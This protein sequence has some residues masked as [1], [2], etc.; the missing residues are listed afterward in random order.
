MGREKILN[1]DCHGADEQFHAIVD[2]M[3]VPLVQGMLKYAFKSDPANALGS[4]TSGSCDKEWAEGW[5]FAAAVLPRLNYCSSTVADFVKAN[6]DT[7]NAAPMTDGFRELKAKVELT[8]PCLGISCADV[9]AFQNSAGIYTG[10][11]SATTS[12]RSPVIHRRRTWSRIRWW[13]WT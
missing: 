7:A 1:Y 2:Q 8:Y 3:T 10:A 11:K 5:A 4:C 6:L 9:G 13:T 12:R